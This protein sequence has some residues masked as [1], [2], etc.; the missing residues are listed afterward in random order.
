MQA[1]LHGCEGQTQHVADFLVRQAFD[2]R[3]YEDISVV[4]RQIS[5]RRF[6]QFPLLGSQ[7]RRVRRDRPHSWVRL[8][9]MIRFGFRD[10]MLMP[11]TSGSFF[12]VGERGIH[13]HAMQPCTE[14]GLTTE[15]IKFPHDL[16]QHIG[17]DFFCIRIIAEHPTRDGVDARGIISKD[18]FRCQ[19]L[20]RSGSLRHIANIRK[21]TG[22]YGMVRAL[23]FDFDG[24]LADSFDGITA[25]TN[26]VRAHYGLAEL[27]EAEVRLHVG[28]GLRNLIQRLIPHADPVEAVEL[29]RQHHPSVMIRGTR[30]FDGVPETL[31]A[32]QARGRKLAVC[33]N[34]GVQFTKRLVEGLGLG[35][36]FP[37]ILGPEDVGAPKP[38]PAMLLEALDRLEVSKEEAIYIGDMAIDV[39][40]A[41]SAGVPVWIMP[42]G[43]HGTPAVESARPDRILRDFREILELVN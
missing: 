28:L 2:I 33:S 38:D 26:Y 42:G 8:W 12:A 11:G 29:Y 10:N 14:G 36:Y 21:P 18:R 9:H 17:G 35:P 3:Q 43:A 22:E 1:A 15:R 40:T 25:S 39:Q 41:R 23:L 7:H 5:D 19:R 24:T 31:A 13:C 30:L 34:K 16:Q 27:S 4:R 37:V 32:L 20:R 6:N